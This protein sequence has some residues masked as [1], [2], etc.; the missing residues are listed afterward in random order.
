MPPIYLR[1]IVGPASSGLGSL[2]GVTIIG[3]LQY[4][5]KLWVPGVLPALST[6]VG[7]DMPTNLSFGIMITAMDVG[8]TRVV[9]EEEWCFC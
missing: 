4:D 8:R 9:H 3:E 2:C 1:I 5:I 7:H 6:N